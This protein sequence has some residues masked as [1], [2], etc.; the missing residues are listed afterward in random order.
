MTFPIVHVWGGNLWNL[1]LVLSLFNSSLHI[2][3]SPLRVYD[4]F[5]GFW[6]G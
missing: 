2:V 1:C 4:N 6:T 5:T 3:D